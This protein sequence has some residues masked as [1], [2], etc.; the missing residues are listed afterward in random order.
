MMDGTSTARTASLATASAP[1]VL[2]QALMGVLTA[3]RATS[4]RM[5]DVCKAV[6]SA[7]TSTTLQ[8]M[9]SN[10]AKNVMPAV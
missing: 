1:P 4:W 10:P 8:K 6:V 7:I 2:E 5:G 9:A 3:Q